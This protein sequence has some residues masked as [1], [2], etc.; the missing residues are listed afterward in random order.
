[1][2][3]KEFKIVFNKKGRE[4]VIRRGFDTMFLDHTTEFINCSEIKRGEVIGAGGSR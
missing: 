4:R 2:G 1:M 3:K